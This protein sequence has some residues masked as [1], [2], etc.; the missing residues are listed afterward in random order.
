MSKDD[1][2]FGAAANLAARVDAQSRNHWEW[3]APVIRV[4]ARIPGLPDDLT[5]PLKY[6]SQHVDYLLR[7]ELKKTPDE[8]LACEQAIWG[9]IVA[10]GQLTNINLGTRGKERSEEWVRKLVDDIKLYSPAQY[11]RVFSE[12]SQYRDREYEQMVARWGRDISDMTG[13]DSADEMN[14]VGVAT[15]GS[16]ILVKHDREL[17]WENPELAMG[18]LVHRISHEFVH[19]ES[20]RQADPSL[21][22]IG[23]TK[24]GY[25]ERW[26]GS[27]FERLLHLNEALTELIGVVS[28]HLNNDQRWEPRGLGY[29]GPA[30]WVDDALITIAGRAGVKP[31]EVLGFLHRGMIFGNR[32][33]LEDVLGV[34]TEEERNALKWM[35]TF[36]YDSAMNR[37]LSWGTVVK[38]VPSSLAKENLQAARAGSEVALLGGEV[39]IKLGA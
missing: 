13:L 25:A 18:Q 19:L 24:I 2:P 1:S 27:V 11:E 38:H 26:R 17:L 16:N 4:E 37:E 34:L 30:I 32:E 7:G 12:L 15:I 9:V 23:H 3:G 5:F 22:V 31:I 33:Y 10:T 29:Q 6:E 35:E 8:Q 20:D 39:V 28:A 36:S 21:S 14:E